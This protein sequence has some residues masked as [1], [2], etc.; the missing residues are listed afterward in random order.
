MLLSQTS[1]QFDLG[2]GRS[3][4]AW[5]GRAVPVFYAA[6]LFAVGLP[7]CRGMR[8][9]DSRDGQM[10]VYFTLLTASLLRALHYFLRATAWDDL[11]GG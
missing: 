8:G 3:E 6:V 4:S 9:D 5:C 7:C 2:I 11:V 1:G 10:N